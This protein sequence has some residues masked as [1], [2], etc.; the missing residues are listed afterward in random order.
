[1]K[2]LWFRFW[3]YLLS[4]VK[5]KVDLRILEST[6]VHVVYFN[7]FNKEVFIC[8]DGKSAL[9]LVDILNSFHQATNK[10]YI[11]IF[12]GKASEV[13]TYKILRVLDC[14]FTW[15]ATEEEKSKIFANIADVPIKRGE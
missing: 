15:N 14:R 13:F 10:T 2:K 8:P 12:Y 9:K 11:K 5:E 3:E 4:K 7:E 6:E 1:M